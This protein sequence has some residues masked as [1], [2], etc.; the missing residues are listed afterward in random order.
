MRYH[1]N[2]KSLRYI[3]IALL[4]AMACGPALLDP[5]LFDCH[6]STSTASAAP[7]CHD[8][9]SHSGLSLSGVSSCDHDHDALSADAVDVR[10][11]L[12]HHGGAPALAAQ[13]PQRLV[14]ASALLAVVAAGQASPPR[15]SLHALDLPLRL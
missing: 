4:V 8:V 12:G 15:S 10:L 1:G 11:A 13:P 2:V 14:A 9:A 5:C 3:A 7:P 6:E